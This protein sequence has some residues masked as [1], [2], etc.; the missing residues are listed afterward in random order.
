MRKAAAFLWQAG[1]A[2]VLPAWLALVLRVGLAFALPAGLVFLFLAGTAFAQKKPITLDALQAPRNTAARSTPGDPVWAPDGKAFV[3]RQGSELKGFDVAAKKSCDVV[4]LTAL[5][6]GALSP[7][8]PE[9]H[10]WENRL[11]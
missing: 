5:D 1:L 8:A 6:N 7:P 11:V 4:G 9:R 3:F 2:L 10:E